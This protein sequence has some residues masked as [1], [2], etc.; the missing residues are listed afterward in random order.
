MAGY[1]N[2]PNVVGASVLSLGCQ[3]LQ[4]ELFL[5]QLKNT[6]KNFDKPLLIFDQQKVEKGENLIQKIIKDS[7]VE[8]EKANQ[9]QRQKT[10]LSKLNLG[11]ECG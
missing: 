2:N 4:V 1:V 9:I 5:E 6:N 11:L 8:I 3:N 10:P 7:W